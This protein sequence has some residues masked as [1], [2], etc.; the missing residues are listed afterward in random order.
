MGQYNGV[1][2]GT[3]A[4][5]NKYYSF[6]IGISTAPPD[7]HVSP[8]II[9]K[10]PGT[11]VTMFC[12]VTGGEPIPTVQW[13]KNDDPII[14]DEANNNNKYVIGKSSVA[15]TILDVYFSDTGAYMCEAK[16]SAGRRIDITSLVVVAGGEGDSQDS[17][18]EGM[19][20]TFSIFI[21][22]L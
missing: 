22:N 10:K 11:N 16:N 6:H 12:R 3:I 8:H 5:S 18:H 15:L 21:S 7:V 14:S 1:D 17:L 9:M 13:L 2:V 20:L 4:H 19:R